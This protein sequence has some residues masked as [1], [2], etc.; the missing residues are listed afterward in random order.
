MSRLVSIETQATWLIRSCMAAMQLFRGL[1]SMLKMC[2][3]GLRLSVNF[4]RMQEIESPTLG[5]ELGFEKLAYALRVT[6][7]PRKK[8]K[9]QASNCPCNLSPNV[10]TGRQINN[11]LQ[12]WI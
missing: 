10:D 3:L 5:L 11:G 8:T 7:L 4:E 12:C 1:F 9:Y 6:E 2:R